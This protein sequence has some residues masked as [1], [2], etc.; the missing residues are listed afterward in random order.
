MISDHPKTEAKNWK[1]Q[2]YADIAKE[3]YQ[4]RACAGT[5]YASYPVYRPNMSREEL[6]SILD[7]KNGE[8]LPRKK[9]DIVADIERFLKKPKPVQQMVLDSGKHS[10]LVELLAQS[11]RHKPRVWLT[12]AEYSQWPKEHHRFG[13]SFQYLGPYVAADGYREGMP[14]DQLRALLELHQPEGPINATVSQLRAELK[15]RCGE[16]AK[17]RKDIVGKLLAWSLRIGSSSPFTAVQCYQDEAAARQDE[18]DARRDEWAA[19]LREERAIEAQ[20]LQDSNPKKKR[21]KKE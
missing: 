7:F 15:K 14:K 12:N 2:A 4:Q 19:E 16:S 5:G 21:Q 8:T 3:D 9:A 10:E 6:C 18:F 13:L 17:G 11:L 20:R 1:K